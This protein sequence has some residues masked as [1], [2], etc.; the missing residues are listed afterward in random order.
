MSLTSALNAARSGLSFTSRWAQTT[1]TNIANTD[2]PGYAR[3]SGEVVTT[4]MGEPTIRNVVRATDASL[5]R[6]YWMETARASRQEAMAGPLALH[7]S[8]LGDADSADSMLSKLTDF[9][10][11]LGLLSS[12]PADTAMQRAAVT[13]AQELARAFNDAHGGLQKAAVAAQD[14][15]EREVAQINATLADLAD[16]NRR[17]VRT[18]PGS[19]LRLSLED[20]RTQALDSLA[21]RMDFTV[22]YD[23]TGQAELFATGGAALLQGTDPAELS[24]DPVTLTL[25]AGDV[26]ITPGGVGTR[27]LSEGALAGQLQLLTDTIPGMQAQLD[28]A[29][30]ALIEG[31]QDADTSLGPGDAGL[32]TDAGAALVPPPAPGLAGRLA[33]NTAVR[34]E[35]GG[36]LWRIRDGMG[37]ASQ[38]ASGDPTLINAFS[39]ILDGQMSFDGSVGLGDG[40]TLSGYLATLIASQQSARA[41]AASASET[42]SAGAEAVQSRRMAFMGVNVDDELQQLMRIEQAYAA[43]SQVMRAASDMI[44]TLLSAF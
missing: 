20:Q 27:G 41:E 26:D 15:A 33:V 37:A 16:L 8:V 10:N 42:L 28:E 43:N 34:P 4:G 1:S 40:G 44:E 38:G 9:R 13:D 25:M 19:D 23:Q 6:M 29:A 7:G 22:R 11:A 3:R 2:T 21:P 31:F 24:F 17:I 35:A 39:A 36:A 5:D 32:F 30:R 14:A 12:S 18:E